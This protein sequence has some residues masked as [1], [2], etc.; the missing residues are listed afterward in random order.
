M[1]QLV[2]FGIP[3]SSYLRT[4]RLACI[5]KQVPHTVESVAIGSDALAALHPWRRVPILQHGDLRLYETSAIA[6]Y[7]DELGS[8]PSLVPATTAARAAMEQWIS[9]I[10]C[11]IY[12]SLIRN[13]ALRYVLAR[14]RGVELDLAAIRAAVPNMERDVG[15]LDGAYA[16]GAWLAGDTLSLADLFVAPIAQTISMFPEGK[17]ALGGAKHLSRAFEALAGRASYQQVHAGLFD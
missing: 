7:I 14:Q 15:L 17:A 6:R 9:A 3:R 8:G 16:G 4:A 1:T 12:D 13:Y 2:L 5:E 11:Y 10:N